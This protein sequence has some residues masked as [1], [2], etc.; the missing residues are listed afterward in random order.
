MA[1]YCS[2]V[3]DKVINISKQLTMIEEHFAKVSDI[4][5]GLLFQLQFFSLLEVSNDQ[6]CQLGYTKCA[7]YHEIKN[8]YHKHVVDTCKREI[9]FLSAYMRLQFTWN[10][11][12]FTR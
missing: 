4:A 10:Y 6:Q 12:K 11:R 1:L 3:F 9:A 7:I 2:H 8:D 5:L